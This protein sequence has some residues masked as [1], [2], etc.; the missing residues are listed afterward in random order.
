VIVFAFGIFLC[1]RGA[2]SR[3]WEEIY[4]YVEDVHEWKTT[5]MPQFSSTSISL[6]TPQNGSVPLV[7]QIGESF[8]EYSIK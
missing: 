8:A 4:S 7:K 6:Q 5:Y 1:K 3:R 2:A